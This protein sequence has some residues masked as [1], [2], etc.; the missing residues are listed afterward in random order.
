MDFGQSF[1][2]QTTVARRKKK[3]FDL[4]RIA[5]ISSKDIR[6]QKFSR[7]IDHLYLGEGWRVKENP[8]NHTPKYSYMGEM[9]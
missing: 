3:S 8:L 6:T 5:K 7:S 1:D 2:L 9:S 4:R